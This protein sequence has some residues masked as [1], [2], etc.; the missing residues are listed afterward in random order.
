MEVR[1]LRPGAAAG[2]PATDTGRRRCWPGSGRSRSMCRATV[3]P[4]SSP[5]PWPSASG[6]YPVSTSWWI[7]LSAKGL[8]TGEVQAHL[9]EVYGAEISWQTIS[10][11]DHRQGDRGHGRV[12][13]PAAR[14]GRATTPWIWSG[15]PQR[16]SRVPA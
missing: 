9:A 10:I 14:P 2:I 5:R 4:P 1:D 3:T 15:C 7:S 8:T 12:A 13:E 16:M 11:H 6:A